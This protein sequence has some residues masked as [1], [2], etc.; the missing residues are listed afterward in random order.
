MVT[1]SF[2]EAEYMALSDTCW[3]VKWMQSLFEEI[4][5]FF[6]QVPIHGDNQGSIFIGSN[7]IQEQRTKHIDICYYYICKCIEDKSV[8]VSFLPGCDM[9]KEFASYFVY[10]ISGVPQNLFPRLTNSHAFMAAWLVGGCWNSS[11][12]QPVSTYRSIT[13]ITVWSYLYMVHAPWGIH[14]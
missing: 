2:T 9:H 10:K 5:F 4:S 1:L 6:G 8:S 13:H 14:I 7:P 12:L 3:Q 11:S